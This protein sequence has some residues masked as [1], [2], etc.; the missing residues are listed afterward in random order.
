[1][2]SRKFSSESITLQIKIVI[3]QVA[4][5]EPVFKLILEKCNW[6]LA[7]HFIHLLFFCLYLFYTDYTIQAIQL[8]LPLFSLARTSCKLYF[9]HF[10]PHNTTQREQ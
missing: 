3:I 9:S 2:T 6:D 4:V 7:I 10:Q 1:M 8:F 5:Q